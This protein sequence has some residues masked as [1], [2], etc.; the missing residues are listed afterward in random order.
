M[1]GV[2][3][4][5]RDTSDIESSVAVWRAAS[6]ARRGGKPVS[7]ER[8]TKV[9]SSLQKSDSFLLVAD[10][11][12]EVVGMALGMQG[13]AGDGTGPP[14]LGLCFVSMVFVAPDHWGKGLG[15]S[16]LDAVLSEARSRGYARA[17]LWTHADN[18]RAQRLYE[19]RGFR[20]SGREMAND[21]G[22]SIVQYERAL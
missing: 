8:E 22:E 21:G 14:V 12:G 15:G 5:L 4:R 13:L 3:V 10:D 20:R 16:I 17:E 2:L 1:K 7:A 19:G 6:C 9:R 18:L 11:E